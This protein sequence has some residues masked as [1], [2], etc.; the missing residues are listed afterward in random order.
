[1]GGFPTIASGLVCADSDLDGMPDIWENARGLDS[2]N[3][4]D[5]NFIAPNGYTYLENYL[6]GV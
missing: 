3:A 2:K 4:A 5:R 1:V 6:N